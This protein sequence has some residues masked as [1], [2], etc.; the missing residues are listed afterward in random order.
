MLQTGDWILVR[1]FLEKGGTSKVRAHW[2]LLVNKIKEGT[3][4]NAVI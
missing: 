3:G 4:G 2:E 1:N